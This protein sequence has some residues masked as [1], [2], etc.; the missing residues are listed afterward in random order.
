MSL[1]LKIKRIAGYVAPCISWISWR[2]LKAL[3]NHGVYFNLK[4]QDWQELQKKLS[5]DYYIILTRSNGYLST[6]LVALGH[7]FLTGQKGY[8]SHALMNLEESTKPDVDTGFQ[9]FEATS[10][11][12]H[13]SGFYDVFRCDS[14][15]LLRPSGLKIRDWT[16]IFETLLAQEGKKY[17]N[18]M[19]LKSD[20]EINCVE[21]VRKALQTLPDYETRFQNFERIIQEYDGNLTP[22]MF[23]HCK[24]FVVVYEARR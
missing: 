10:K 5:K 18:F 4:P 13:Y 17:D 6:H 7:R 22:D 20:N 1:K 23:Y 14:V 8:W 12:V 16:A 24:D 21:L 15:A 3:F 9:L 19:D 2:S 11:G